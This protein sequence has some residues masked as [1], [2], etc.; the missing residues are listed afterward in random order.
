MVFSIAKGLGCNF[1]AAVAGLQLSRWTSQGF[2]EL[3]WVDPGWS[4]G[5]STGF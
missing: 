5:C 2:T 1:P 4:P 3:T